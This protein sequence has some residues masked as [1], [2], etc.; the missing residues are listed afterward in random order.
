MLMHDVLTAAASPAPPAEM[1][2][3]LYDERPR[4]RTPGGPPITFPGMVSE[5]LRLADPLQWFEESAGW[6]PPFSFLADFVPHLARLPQID[7]RPPE[8]VA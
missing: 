6:R 2:S 3:P 8:G 5:K 4:R 7:S 1:P